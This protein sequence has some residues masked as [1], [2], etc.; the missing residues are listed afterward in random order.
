MDL[1]IRYVIYGTHLWCTYKF[2]LHVYGAH[3]W[4]SFTYVI[5]TTLVFC[6][7]ILLMVV[8]C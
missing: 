2:M 1:G 3:L 5:K 8:F 7:V 4:C 6:I